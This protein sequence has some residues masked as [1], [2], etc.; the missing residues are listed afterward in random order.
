MANRP[1]GRRA[2]YQKQKDFVRLGE[3]EKKRRDI[4]RCAFMIVTIARR[5]SVEE[6]QEEPG[7]SALLPKHLAWPSSFP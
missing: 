7:A 4:H 3:V 5:L 2:R 6:V 1:G